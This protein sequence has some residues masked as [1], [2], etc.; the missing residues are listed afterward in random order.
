VWVSVSILTLSVLLIVWYFIIWPIRLH[1]KGYF[2][3]KA[4]LTGRLNIK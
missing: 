3:Q 1:K 2:V 4:G